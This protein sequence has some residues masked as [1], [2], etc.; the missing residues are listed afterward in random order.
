LEQLQG[1]LKRAFAIGF[2]SEFTAFP[3]YSPKVEL[4]Q[5]A[6]DTHIA[7]VDCVAFAEEDLRELVSE[8]E[9]KELILHGGQLDLQILREYG[10][11]APRLFETQVAA[12]LTMATKGPIG[13]GALLEHS[14]EVTVPKGDGAKDWRPRPIPTQMIK[15]AMADVEHLHQLRRNLMLELETAGRMDWFREEM[16]T[17]LEPVPVVDDFDLWKK[18]RRAWKLGG[19]A[20]SLHVLQAL[21]VWRERAGR[22]ARLAPQLIA[23]D[24]LLVS[25]ANSKPQTEQELAMFPG[26]KAATVRFNKHELL[27]CIRGGGDAANRPGTELVPPKEWSASVESEIKV[28]ALTRLFESVVTSRALELGIDA[29]RLGN[30]SAIAELVRAEDVAE[31]GGSVLL[32]GWRRKAVG[33]DLLELKYQR[34]GLGWD[35]DGRLKVVG[36]TEPVYSDV[37]TDESR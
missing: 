15:Y 19:C 34:A 31:E 2:D 22:K 33:D 29:S 17:F 9:G 20:E 16:D 3:L 30:Q 11:Q 32:Q 36:N 7:C 1:Q 4:M 6:T 18:I 8:M 28:L 35:S 14:L 27:H 13:L 25:L 24:N 23:N 10:L 21:T 37:Q 12:G 26:L 5:F